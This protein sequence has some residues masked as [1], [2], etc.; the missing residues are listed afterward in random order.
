MSEGTHTAFNQIVQDGLLAANG[1]ASFAD[2]VSP[3]DT[4]KIH[5]YIKA[6]AEQDR[7]AAAGEV[8]LAQLTWQ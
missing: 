4:T 2:V 6:R 5:Q 7:L 8:E 1:M 3:E